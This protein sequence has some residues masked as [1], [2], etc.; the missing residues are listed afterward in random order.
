MERTTAVFHARD[1]MDQAVRELEARGVVRERIHAQA[2]PKA[3]RMPPPHA[4]FGIPF[5]VHYAGAGAALGML[6]GLAF[7]G[8]PSGAG[9]LT[10]IWLVIVGAGL[11]AM[12][13]SFVGLLVG[14]LRRVRWSDRVTPHRFVLRVDSETA[15]EHDAVSRTITSYGGELQHA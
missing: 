2:D 1:R 9:P 3:H 5:G 4:L 7:S 8:A 13:G 14:G 10:T 6:T 11:G 12:L 15:A